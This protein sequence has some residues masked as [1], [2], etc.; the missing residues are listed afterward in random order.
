[1]TELTDMPCKE[2]PDILWEAVD[3]DLSQ[4]SF[5]F[6]QSSDPNL[7]DM[8]HRFAPK[9][10]THAHIPQSTTS[11]TSALSGAWS[12]QCRDAM[13]N[14][15]EL[16]SQ[17]KLPHFQGTSNNNL[18]MTRPSAYIY[19]SDSII[20]FPPNHLLMR[21]KRSSFTPTAGVSFTWESSIHQRDLCKII[22]SRRKSEIPK[23]LY[24]RF[25]MN[26]S[27]PYCAIR[28]HLSAYIP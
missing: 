24:S 27:A 1:M 4:L 6:S 7:L 2:E 22:W 19:R 20:T 21:R 23:N 11:T 18:V 17:N 10:G 28:F 25:K 15:E 5:E 8:I 12:L 3:F 9:R 26:Y 14:L 16:I 13:S